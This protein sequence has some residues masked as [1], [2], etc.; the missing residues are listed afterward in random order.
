M[1]VIAAVEADFQVAPPGTR[2]RLR[3]ALFGETVLRRTLRRVAAAGRLGGVHL[4]VKAEEETP[5]REAAAGLPV[6]VET[7]Q[8]GAPPWQTLVA[9]ARKWSLDAWRGGLAG[10]T[11][12]DE[13]LNP[14]V[15]E[16][17]ARREG[18]DA[19]AAVPAAAVLLDPA[20]LDAM[21]AHYEKVRADVRMTFTQSA[22]GL[23][24][25][26]YATALL[27]DLARTCQPPGRMMAYRP[28]EPQ[29]DMV[30]QPCYYSPE[31]PIAY[32][33]GRLLADTDESLRR[34]QSIGDLP[35]AVAVS[36]W[37]VEHRH[38]T[39]P[40]PAEL[41]IELTTD[42]PLRATT[43][44][45]RGDAIGRRGPMDPALFERLIDE[46]AARDD[47][48]VVLGGFGD[49]LLHP[50]WPALVG[51]CRQAGIFG[52]AVRATAVHLDERAV[53]AL[54]E[55]R[56]D[57]LNVLVDAAST[58]TYA[59]VHRADLFEQ[60]MANIERVFTAHRDSRQ[61]LPL[62]VCEMAKTRDTMDE[63]ERFYDLWV[64]RSG[65]AVIV[66]PSHYAG[67]WPD[68]AVMRMAPPGRFACGRIYHR[69]MV[70]ADGRLTVCDQDYRGEH[71][72]G[73]LAGSRLAD[74]WR[75]EAL[76]AVR[77]GHLGGRYDGM[78][79]CPRCDEWHRP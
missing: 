35:E 14:W 71:A 18:A 47:A 19:V 5:A 25:P 30:M 13:H 8:A 50:S 1:K 44:R 40:L 42:D 2:S 64:A 37:L 56:V 79:L 34:I 24:A 63:M 33:T 66:G 32:A 6:K 53:Q 62:V 68:L 21:I 3:D 59:K 77:D 10:A 75:G 28:A 46:L 60:V 12:F 36:R 72:A 22:P 70:L 41:E 49:P 55:N 67:Q 17:L 48:R 20:L 11:V 57:V 52:L 7:H 45:P 39:G 74:L 26:I 78:P 29:R 23:S 54:V 31:P 73:S 43:L 58:G 4:V 27:A 51:R 76:R 16:A 38:D 15:L 9:S 61:P 65:S 69:A